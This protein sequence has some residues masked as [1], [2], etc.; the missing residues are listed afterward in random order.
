MDSLPSPI[1]DLAGDRQRLLEVLDGA[2]GLPQVGVAV[3][4]VAEPRAF[5]SAILRL[6]GR[7]QR[8]FVA[9]DGFLDLP[10]RSCSI[11]PRL[12]TLIPFSVG[13][14]S[15]PCSRSCSSAISR[16]V[17]PQEQVVEVNVGQHVGCGIV[18]TRGAAQVELGQLRGQ[19][20]QGFPFGAG[21]ADLS[22]K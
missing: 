9:G 19:V 10:C 1:P 8:L 21:L 20:V 3:A 5:G 12:P 16:Y 15:L 2:G 22:R 6:A 4:Q 11:W 18:L 14:L 13:S 17:A 7:R